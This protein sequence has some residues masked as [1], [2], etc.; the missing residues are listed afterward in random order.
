MQTTLLSDK[1]WVYYTHNTNL[2][3]IYE[4]KIVLIFNYYEILAKF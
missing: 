4:L 2:A 1:N 3:I